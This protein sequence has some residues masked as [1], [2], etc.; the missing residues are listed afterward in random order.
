MSL[1]NNFS[2]L[3]ILGI[4]NPKLMKLAFEI[5]HSKR[6]FLSYATLYNLVRSF[7]SLQKRTTNP[8]Q[9]AEFGVGRGGS[10]TILAWLVNEK[11]GYLTLFDVFGQI[12]AP[13]AMDGERAKDRYDMIVNKE[14]ADYYG[15]ISN[16]RELVLID[17][18]KV[19]QPDRIQVV[20]GRYEELLP[21][22]ND[23]RKFDLVHI[24]CDWYES[25]KVV[26]E[27]IHTRL[28]VG[29]IIQVDD[30]ST[31]EGSKK[32]YHETR[33]LEPFHTFI[34]DGALVLDTSI[35]RT[36]NLLTDDDGD[37]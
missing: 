11:Q 1:I 24:D 14:S 19:C 8:L 29:A 34:V 4:K 2:K 18:Y 25:S 30:Y 27:Y 15:N 22:L 7:D 9:V 3:F 5:K 17:L 36:Q 26:Y 16:L 23:S 20:Q 31:W 6:T 33:W 12:P 21:E 37:G 28:N 13:T 35:N 32:A 10:A